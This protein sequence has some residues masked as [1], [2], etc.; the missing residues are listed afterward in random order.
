M[1]RSIRRLSLFV[2]TAALLVIF[3]VGFGDR[4]VQHFAY[5]VER[6][7]L[8][9]TTEEL[10]DVQDTA[11]LQA[12]SNAFRMVAKVARPGVV[13]IDVSGG[14]VTQVTPEDIQR[15]REQLGEI[16]TDE[17]IKRLLLRRQPP[18]SGSGM[19]FD[20]EGHILTNSHVV[21]DRDKIQ[22]QTADERTYEAT[23]VGVDPKTDV[24]VI[25][26]DARDL[27]PLK[28]ADSDK[29]EVG[30]WVVAVGA[31]FGLTQTVTHGI[32]S[33]T[34]RTRIAG[35]SGIT[36][37][38]FIQTDAAINPGNSGGPLLNL[39]GEVLGVNTAIATNGEAVNAGVA[40]TIPSNMAVKIAK[41]LIS[42]GTVV[43]GWLGVSFF[44]AALTD[45]DR[46]IFKLPSSRGVLV[47]RVLKGSPAEKAG[48]EVE[49]VIIQCN[50]ESVRNTDHFREQIADMGADEVV[51]LRIVRDG[52]EQEIK[53][54]L[55][56]QPDDIRAANRDGGKEGRP[57]SALGLAG[58]S[59]RP[60]LN[61][62][63]PGLAR[64]YDDTERG[65][66]VMEI[67]DPAQAPKVEPGEVIVACN[68]KE[69]KSVGEL[70]KIL[71]DAP[72]GESI[73]LQILEKGGDRRIIPFKR[74]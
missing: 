13:S 21:A 20:A 38:N 8:Q 55:G 66:L 45:E 27:H 5:A 15:M 58:R 33:A 32:I 68:G 23:L 61:Q 6:G 14:R 70:V 67:S 72:A 40:F 47:E 16:L 69:L 71:R 39:R 2:W 43:R 53:V 42:K 9:A 28:F 35:L 56:R 54:Q 48:L 7:R 18:A 49:D 41:Q 29:A 64:F 74:P 46:D 63:Y 24:A 37:Q 31:P 65:V 1:N 10:A 36:Y 26:I 62:T 52:Q 4:V 57:V 50:G 22:V 12:V 25:K 34:G 30:D 73:R 51:A 19:V 3:W 17:Q 59:L 44:P 11:S 60:G